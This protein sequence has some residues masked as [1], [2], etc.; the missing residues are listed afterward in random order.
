MRFLGVVLALATLAAA[1]SWPADAAGQVRWVPDEFATIQAAVDAA[2]AGDIIRVR[3]GVYREA[4]DVGLGKEGLVIAGDG[5][6]LTVLDGNGDHQRGIHVTADGV[7]V[8]DLTLRNYQYTGTFY[9]DVDGFTMERLEAADNGE[10]GLFAV[11]SQHGVVRD[12]LAH[13]HRDGGLYIGESLYCFC[14]VEN[15]E[16]WDN[17][18]GYSGTASNFV[19]IRGNNFHDNRAGLLFSTLPDEPGIQQHSTVV[20]NWV[21]HNN[22]PVPAA[23]E[24]GVFYVPVGMGI[25]VAGGSSNA[26]A[27]NR[28][29]DNDLFGIAL[30]WLFAP[31]SE[32]Q[33][34]R[35]TLVDN[36]I[37]LWWDE[38]GVNNCFEDNAYASSDP[39]PLPSCQPVAPGVPLGNAGIPSARKDAWLATVGLLQGGQP[40]TPY[41]TPL[42]PVEPLPI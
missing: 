6:G 25:V 13:G 40:G 30:F 29:E 38:W 12:S 4:V 23:P 16:A 42:G 15:N 24:A 5:I 2:D 14:T 20:G 36:G 35:N 10:Y 41:Q 1:V 27:E 34:R 31:P 11:R 18:M 28:V 9:E 37:D 26:I 19:T 33:V 3:A 17:V 8:R 7:T 22:N 21:H 39:V 32:N